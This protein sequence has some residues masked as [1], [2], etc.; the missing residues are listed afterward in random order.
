MKAS[1]S[2]ENL[3]NIAIV[4]LAVILVG[5]LVRGYF[6]GT[7][8]AQQPTIGEKLEIPSITQDKAE[9]TLLVALRN[10][11][12][13]CEDSRDFYQRLLLTANSKNIRVIALFEKA[14]P[15]NSAF[16]ES[17]NPHFENVLVLSFSN[18][19]VDATP[20]II[21]L[22]MDGSVKSVWVGKLPAEKEDQLLRSL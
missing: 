13:F 8:H 3:A 7:A 6:F 22:N 17:M 19:K 15:K 9:R 10:D 16:I 18:I 5:F 11:C 1:K 12:P 14:D 4:G 2:L 20:T 21:D